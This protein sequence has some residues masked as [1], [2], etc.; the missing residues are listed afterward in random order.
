MLLK[1]ALME[2]VVYSFSS[3]TQ[4]FIANLA[5][6]DYMTFRSQESFSNLQATPVLEYLCNEKGMREFIIWGEKKC[7]RSVREKKAWEWNQSL[8]Y[9]TDNA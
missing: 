7:L 3:P 1:G 5:D 6:S 9:M 2:V 4:V 8:H